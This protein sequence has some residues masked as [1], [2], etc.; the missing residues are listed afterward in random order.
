MMSRE[1]GGEEIIRLQ[2]VDTLRRT[3]VTRWMP[4][5]ICSTFQRLDIFHGVK[6][7]RFVVKVHVTSYAPSHVVIQTG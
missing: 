7:Q 1:S 3:L 4:V 2:R 6:K 5:D